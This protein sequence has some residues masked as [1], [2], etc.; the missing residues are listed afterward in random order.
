MPNGSYYSG[1]PL[2]IVTQSIT[3]KTI[4]GPGMASMSWNYAYGAANASFAPCSG[5][6]TN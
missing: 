1:K 4:T 5:C 2:Y 6:V 3:N